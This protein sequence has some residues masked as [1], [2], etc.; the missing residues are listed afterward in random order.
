MSTFVTSPGVKQ[1]ISPM[2]KQII[3]SPTSRQNVFENDDNLIST[4]RKR[5][6]R[7]ERKNE[8]WTS[9]QS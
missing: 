6:T 8:T 9:E 3:I 4:V 1:I 2:L 5:R 7:D